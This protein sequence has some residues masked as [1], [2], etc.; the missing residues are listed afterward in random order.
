MKIKEFRQ[1]LLQSRNFIPVKV[2]TLKYQRVCVCEGGVITLPTIRKNSQLSRIFDNILS[3]FSDFCQNTVDFVGFYRFYVF[4]VGFGLILTHTPTHTVEAFV[5][6]LR[7]NI[8]QNDQVLRGV[9]LRTLF[10]FFCFLWSW[11][12]EI[13]F[14]DIR[15]ESANF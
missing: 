10:A 6:S 11:R 14:C 1:S 2:S 9:S 12:K 3:I 15:Y 7:P 8:P 4:S 13:K 5:T